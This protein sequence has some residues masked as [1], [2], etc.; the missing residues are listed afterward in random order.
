MSSRFLLLSLIIYTFVIAGLTTLNGMLIAMALPFVVFLAAAYQF[1]PG[2]VQI[3]LQ[4]AFDSSFVFPG[5]EVEVTLT[6]ANTGKEAYEVR[7]EDELPE[8]LELVDGPI[9]LLSILN[10][11]QSVDMKYTVRGK[12]G[13]YAFR[14]VDITVFD[15]LGL[16]T[17]Q[18]KM[19]ATGMLLVKPDIERLRH[20]AVR[21]VRTH[22]FTGAIPGRQGGSGMNFFGVRNY[23][24]GDLQRR[25][26]WK[27]TARHDM[28]LFTN[29][30]ERERVAD[31]G[32]ILDARQRTDVPA[33]RGSLFEYGVTA[34]AAL[35][36]M[37][38]QSG[39]RVGLLIY[40]RSQEA[41]FPGFGKMQREKILRALAQAGTGDNMALES[42]TY[43]P[44]R[45]FPPRSQVV[46]IS[47][48]CQEDLPVLAR[49]RAYGY[50]LLI[51]SPNPVSY[52]SLMYGYQTTQPLAVR[53]A[54][55]ERQL[56]L[57]RLQRTGI[58]VVDWHVENP[59][60]QSLYT[61]IGRSVGQPS[62]E[63]LAI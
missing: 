62:R 4:R 5:K 41:T 31:V 22:G 3:S 24:L 40:G 54:T 42:F 8:G 37:F 34:A 63:R 58:L 43:L 14:S 15:R 32:L 47:P 11:G 38:L 55:L 19:E 48:L 60:G 45:F 61:A 21:P 20:L 35:S 39:N 36:D 57:R 9:R 46:L 49:L 12:R 26:N 18:M 33:P 13:G 16:F 30:F 52:E 44:T 25:I 17:R 10:P 29:E 7:I 59:L 28:A 50:Q 6:V 51:V 27:S 53:I 56:L 23:Q 2:E 1:T